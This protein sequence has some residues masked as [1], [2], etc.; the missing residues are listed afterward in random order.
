MNAWEM[1]NK[2]I[3]H[4]LAEFDIN[5][6]KNILPV[7]PLWNHSPTFSDLNLCSK[8]I[9]Y[10][11]DF[12]WKV[13]LLHKKKLPFCL[14]EVASNLAQYQ[15]K[16]TAK[17]RKFCN[18][19]RSFF[20]IERRKFDTSFDVS[21]H[22]YLLLLCY[23]ESISPMLVILAYS[24]QLMFST[25]YLG[26]KFYCFW[27]QTTLCISANGFLKYLL[28]PTRAINLFVFVSFS[29]MMTGFSETT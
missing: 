8:S 11:V 22:F 12:S 16:I 21:V 1:S 6:L 23:R 28:Q 18:G 3:T 2:T 26:N 15:W 27:R 5:I 7:E 25:R 4:R 13:H 17:M 24:N 29:F 19:P 14:N 10:L 9:D 20:E